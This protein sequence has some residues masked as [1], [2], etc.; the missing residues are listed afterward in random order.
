MNNSVKYSTWFLILF[1]LVG[2]IGF[3]LPQTHTFFKSLTPFALLMSA[4]FLAW[5]HR[6]QFSAKTGFVFALIFLFS[7]LAEMVG[8]QTGAIFGH[9]IYGNSLGLKILETPLIIGLNWLMLIYCTKIIADYITDNEIIKPF[10]AALLMVGY[11][12]ILEQAA[13][14]LDMWSWESG[15]VPIQNYIAW[16]LFAFF[17][18]LM[19]R[20]AKIQFKNPLALPVFIIQFL[21]FVTLIIYFLIPGV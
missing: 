18:H 16:Y 4:G 14:M 1:Y 17:F 15:K 21:F 5:F 9:Y 13:P 7:F 8:V 6:P 19:I 12:L 20:K 3:V 11:D 10:T 2:V